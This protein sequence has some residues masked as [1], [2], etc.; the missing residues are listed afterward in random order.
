MDFSLSEKE[1][2][3]W[4]RAKAFTA[5]H[6]TPKAQEHEKRNEF[7]KD[8]VQKAYEAGLM[9][10]HIP[11]EAGGPGLS[12]LAETLVSEATGYGCAGHR[13]RGR[14]APGQCPGRQRTRPGESEQLSRMRISSLV[15]SIPTSS[16]EAE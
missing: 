13:R 9:N 16:W 5:E 10:L 12:L 6:I 11:K 2:K 4:D 3:L 8:V 1:Q 7:P 14:K 15:G